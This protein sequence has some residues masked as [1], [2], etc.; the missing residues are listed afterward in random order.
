MSAGAPR[1]AFVLAGGGSLGAVEVG[2]LQALVEAHVRPDLM[3]GSSAGAVNAAFFAGRPDADGV[4]ALRGIWASLRPRDVFPFSPVGGLLGALALRDHMVDSGPFERLLTRN[5]PYRNLEDAEIPV[6]VVA[7]NVLNGRE[8]LLSKGKAVPAVLAS[9]AIPGVFPPVKIDGTYYFDGS[10]ASN[11][12]ISAAL[13][14]GAERIVVLPTGYS[15]EMKSPPTSAL[16]MALHGINVLVARQLVVDVERFMD[17]ALIRVVPPL[18]PV[19]VHPFDFSAATELMSRAAKTTRAWL[20]RG[21]LDH[22]GIPF[23]LPP[24]SHEVI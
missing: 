7:A 11:T 8:A 18:C 22:T 15:C 10:V 21:G 19:N 2:M 1:T 5:M 20:D 3:V 23:E 13:E 4:H 9:A 6:T 16:A 14:L 12:P 17:H 24:H